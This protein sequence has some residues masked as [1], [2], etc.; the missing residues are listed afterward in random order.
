M[1]GVMIVLGLGLAL[2]GAYRMGR[3][4]ERLAQK[5]ARAFEALDGLIGELRATRKS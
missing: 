1:V 5:E 4:D 3:I 2:Y